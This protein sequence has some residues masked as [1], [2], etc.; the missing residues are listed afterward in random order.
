MRI[1][2]VSDVH[3]RTA[4]LAAAG[5]DCDLFVCLGDLVLFLDYDE[6]EQGIFAD[7][8]G[9]SNA[10]RYIE[11]RTERRFDEARALSRELFEAV[12]ADP[13]P[14]LSEKV[15]AQ[16]AELFAVMPAGLLTYGNVDV[17]TMWAD[18]L[19]PG[20]RVVDGASVTVGGL[21]LGFVGG[22]LRTPM[23]TPFELS[24]EE[25]A[26]KVASLGEVD[27]LFS[28]IPPAVPEATYDVMARRLE[29]GSRVLL[30][31]IRDVQPRYA[32]HGHVHQ[33]LVSRVGVGRTQVINVGHF[34]SRG[35]PTAVT[36]D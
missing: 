36:I 3:H 5:E 27:V 6:P 4:G 29:R 11:L 32:L 31:Y 1:N 20:H 15:A 33:P 7:V 14:V 13:W 18:H 9:G 35:R 10:R 26:A 25:Y 23:R 30:E 17:P 2:V 28:H 24:D 19:R 16:Y 8:F 12:G 22:G 34:R 21:R